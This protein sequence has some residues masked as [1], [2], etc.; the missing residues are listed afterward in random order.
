MPGRWVFK[1]KTNLCQPM[2]MWPQLS[3]CHAC[4]SWPPCDPGWTLSSAADNNCLAK[5]GFILFCIYLFPTQKD[6]PK[7]SQVGFQ[8]TFFVTHGGWWPNARPDPIFDGSGLERCWFQTSLGFHSSTSK[9]V[10]DVGYG[11]DILELASPSQPGHHLAQPLPDEKMRA[12]LRARG[13]HFE[14]WHGW[15]IVGWIRRW[16]PFIYF[17]RFF[18]QSSDVSFGQTDRCW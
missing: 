2:S 4:P 11:S 8:P 14:V 18:L 15:G 17:L 6:D 3:G 5:I 10:P 13:L 12:A 7:M 16:S 9:L 1:T